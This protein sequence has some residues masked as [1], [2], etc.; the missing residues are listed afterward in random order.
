MNLETPENPDF[1]LRYVVKAITANPALRSRLSEF[2]LRGQNAQKSPGSH[3][4]TF[5]QQIFILRSRDDQLTG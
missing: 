3:S 1:M 2:P 4:P 5:F